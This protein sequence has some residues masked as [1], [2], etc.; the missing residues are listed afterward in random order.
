MG[1]PGGSDVKNLFTIRETLVRFLDPEDILAK[2]MAYP[3][4]YSGLENSMDRSSSPWGRK[5]SDM[6]ER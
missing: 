5:E 1:F 2:G 3:L 4:Q 6:T